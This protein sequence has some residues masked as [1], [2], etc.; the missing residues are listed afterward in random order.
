MDDKNALAELLTEGQAGIAWAATPEAKAQYQAALDVAGRLGSAVTGTELSAMLWAAHNA[1]PV[2]EPGDGRTRQKIEL[3][4]SPE[5]TDDGELP[6][7]FRLEAAATPQ[8]RD[9][10]VAGGWTATGPPVRTVLAEGIT[11]RRMQ[12]LLTEGIDWL[13]WDGGLG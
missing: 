2:T 9:G 10:R 3:L 5:G 8:A 11:R 12:A 6:V 7:S 4:F 1:R 13:A